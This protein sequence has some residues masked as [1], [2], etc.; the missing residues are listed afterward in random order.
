[1]PF[2]MIYIILFLLI[3]MQLL[4]FHVW[5]DLIFECDLGND[6]FYRYKNVII[7]LTSENLNNF[8]YITKISFSPLA[9]YHIC[10]NINNKKYFNTVFRFS[11]LHKEIDKLYK[12]K[13]TNYVK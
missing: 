9:S 8:T 11:K 12:N 1:M 3:I 2:M 10:R 13:T 7:N 5:G 4:I 6:K